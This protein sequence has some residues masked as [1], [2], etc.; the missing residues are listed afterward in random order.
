MAVYRH[1]H[2]D[3]WQDGFVLDLTPEEKY[4]YMYLMTNSKTSQCGI[5]ELPKRIMETETGYNRETVEKL[6]ARFKEYGKIVYSEDTKEI[7]LLNWMK[8]NKANSPKVK[9]CIEKELSKIKN[10]EFV[11]VFLDV[12]K[13]IEYCI[14]TLSIDYG[15]K[16][17][18]KEKEKQKQKEKQ[19]EKYKEKDEKNNIGMYAKLYEENIGLINGIASEWLV[20]VSEDI[21]VRLFKRALDI[22]IG[23]RCCNQGYVNGIIKQWRSNNIKSLEDLSLYKLSKDKKG[24]VNYDNCERSVDEEEQGFYRKPTEKELEEFRKFLEENTK[25]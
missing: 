22:A 6:I 24:G 19:K 8:H 14:D 7:F 1:I 10:K 16:E 3:F 25:L 2:I 21:D 23:N 11:G 18:E 13:E 15:E 5:Y 12:C 17:K 20:E 4:F 9:K